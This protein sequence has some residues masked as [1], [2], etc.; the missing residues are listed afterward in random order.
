MRA[1]ALAPNQAEVLNDKANVL[2]SYSTPVA[3]YL[4][5]SC[6]Y[7]RTSKFYSTSTSR[8]INAWLNG[9]PAREVSPEELRALLD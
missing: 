6:E 7:V 2:V 1:K 5:T 8:H 9:N 3:A 4:L